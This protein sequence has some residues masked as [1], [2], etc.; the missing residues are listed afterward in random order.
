MRERI[1][2]RFSEI[3]KFTVNLD[4]ST[5]ITNLCYYLKLPMPIMYKQFSRRIAQ[6]PEYVNIVCIDR[7]NPFHFASLRWIINQ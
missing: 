1:V 3:V 7:S 6:N 5:S 4:S 2:F